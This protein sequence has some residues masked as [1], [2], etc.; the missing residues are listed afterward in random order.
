MRTFRH[1]MTARIFSTLLVVCMAAEPVFVSAITYAA[2]TDG[3][4]VSIKLTPETQSED[5]SRTA[6][7]EA[8]KS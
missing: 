1:S 8:E 2:G 3:V 5:G 6:Q 4:P 7:W